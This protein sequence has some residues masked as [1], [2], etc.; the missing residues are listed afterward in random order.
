MQGRAAQV[1][2]RRVFGGREAG[3]RCGQSTSASSSRLAEITGSVRRTGSLRGRHDRHA[4]DGVIGDAVRRR[5]F[6][7]ESLPSATRPRPRAASALLRGGLR[8][9]LAHRWTAVA[10]ASRHPRQL[11][12][13]PLRCRARSTRRAFGSDDRLGWGGGRGFTLDGTSTTESHAPVDEDI[14]GV[15]VAGNDGGCVQLDRLVGANVPQVPPASNDDRSRIDFS[16]YV[17]CFAQ[18]QNAVRLYFT[19]KLSVDSQSAFE[20]EFSAELRS[21]PE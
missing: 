15:Q 17:G 5:P 13:I 8:A 10:G 1:P 9:R 2:S 21:G 6:D 18:D 11:L 19:S 3:S 4:R 12:G 16:L 20:A 7:R 14:G